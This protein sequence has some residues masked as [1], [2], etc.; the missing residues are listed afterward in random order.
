MQLKITDLN[1]FLLWVKY[2][3]PRSLLLF[4]ERNLYTPDRRRSLARQNIAD[5]EWMT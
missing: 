4:W 2:N 5:P 1:L 3:C